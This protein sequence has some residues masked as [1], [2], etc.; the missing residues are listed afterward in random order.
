VELRDLERP[1]G[2]RFGTL[3]HA[4]LSQVE[5]GADPGAIDRACRAQGRLVGAPPEEVSAAARAVG[6]A[7]KHPLLRRAAAAAECRREEPVLHRLPDG[8]LLEGVVDLAFRDASGWTVVDFKTDAR[9]DS[10]PRYAAQL[11][12]YCAAIT[13]ATGLPAQAALLAV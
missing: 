4:V 3:V 12:L 9:P 6:A 5:L 8:T 7:L 10:H 13:A 11:R 2:K 1:R